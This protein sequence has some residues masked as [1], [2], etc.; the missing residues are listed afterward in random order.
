MAGGVWIVGGPADSPHLAPDGRVHQLADR[1]PAVGEV[2]RREFWRSVAFSAPAPLG[3]YDGRKGNTAGEREQP[4][5]GVLRCQL[6]TPNFQLPRTSKDDNSQGSLFKS[7][8]KLQAAG[9]PS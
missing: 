9:T 6:P 7:A 1:E 8:N 2:R 5:H 3:L 4:G